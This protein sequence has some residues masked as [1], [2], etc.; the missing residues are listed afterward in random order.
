MAETN[1]PPSTFDTSSYY[2]TLPARTVSK[3]LYLFGCRIFDFVANLARHPLSIAVVAVFCAAW[4]LI[5]GQSSENT[6]TLILSVLAITLTQ[7]VL[8]QQRRSEAA[9]HLKIDELILAMSGARDEVAGI[10]TRTE[11]ELEALRRDTA[12]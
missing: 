8:N 12:V 9:V 7:M 11:D 5:D 10:E 6:L 3:R 4:F 1:T 2:K